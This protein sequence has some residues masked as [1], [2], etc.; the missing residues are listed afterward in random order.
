M[1]V[2]RGESRGP[3]IEVVGASKSFIL[4]RQRRLALRELLSPGRFKRSGDDEFWAVKDV[5]FEVR[6]G[7]SVGIVGHNGSGKSTM[8][9]MLTGILKP[10]RGHVTINGRIA[11][12]I[13]V[14]AGF[15]PDLSGRE[16][17]YLNGSILGLSR[18]EIS[19]KFDE[20]VAFAGLERFIDTPVKRYSSG[21]Y[22]RL[23]FSIAI[24]IEPQILL[25]DEVLAVGDALFQR[26]CLRRLE[27][28]VADGGAAV[29]VSHS[30]AQVVD[31]CKTCIWLD[32]GEARF[33]GET[34]AAIDQY[35]AVVAER[36]DVEFKREHP[37]EW[38]ALTAARLLEEETMRAQLEIVEQE[39]E[40]A[41]EAERERKA[42][43]LAVQEAERR[44]DPTRGRILGVTLRDA[45]G[46][47]SQRIN[48]GEPARI[49]IAYEF[50]RKLPDPIF[51]I[52]FYRVSD[53]LHMFTTS[54]YD[55][56][57]WLREMP[58]SGVLSIDIDSLAFSEGTY[59]VQVNLFAECET[60][61]WFDAPEDNHSDA[62]RFEVNAGRF[63]H[64]CTYLA[65]HWRVPQDA[66]HPDAEIRA[67]R[68]EVLA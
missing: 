14:G 56:R 54:N 41:E 18:R 8:L 44:A 58:L 31:L 1:T 62:L 30:M 11:A 49:E 21:M 46:I 25:V 57:V 28:F 43:L 19:A 3:L 34:K 33:I 47:V 52:D 65:T 9:K 12:L 50:G 48:A 60:P 27:Q 2:N 6:P 22:M 15:H 36:E 40:A 4:K 51:G 39:R 67:R 13:E 20:I 32:H 66:A 45:R 55:H 23:G 61:N 35:M 68:V 10:T 37:E 42:V 38:E 59:R 29:F 17:I 64:G 5:S 7:E 53:N 63:A 16:N 26:K 24:H